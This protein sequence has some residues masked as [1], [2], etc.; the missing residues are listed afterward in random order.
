VVD[1]SVDVQDTDAMSVVIVIPSALPELVSFEQPRLM[2]N[3]TASP[4]QFRD[5]QS[6]CP[7]ASPRKRR[8][9]AFTS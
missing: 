1:R 7:P 4:V 2:R 9:R 5:H 3:L 6:D 8:I